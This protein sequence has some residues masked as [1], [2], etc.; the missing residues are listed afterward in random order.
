MSL[1]AQRFFVRYAWGVLGYTVLVVLWGAYVRASGSGAGCGSH[2]PLCNGEV[3]PRSA[4]AETLIEFT[5]RVTSGL[6]LLAVAGLWA[7]SRRLFARGHLARRAAAFSAVFLLIEAVLGAGLVLF[8]YVAQNASVGRALYLSAHL[9]N[10]QLLLAMLTLTAWFA[11]RPLKE[12]EWRALPGKFRAALP[13]ALL[14]GVTGAI[15]ALGDTLF[16]APS[17]AAGIRQETTGSPHWLLQLRLLHPAAS[18]LVGGF[19]LALALGAW[20]RGSDSALRQAGLW[21]GV[22]VLVQLAAGG[23]NVLLLAPIWMQIVHLLLADLL[24]IALV[25]LVV[26]EARR[27]ALAVIEPRPR[28]A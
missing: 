6:D 13:A 14:V 4:E 26:E 27:Q 12:L 10:T 3:I 17:M 20:R 21:T 5:H 16:P 19:L 2:W 24:W 23:I 9:A 18:I 8:E 25:I 7:W 15:A 22:L 11:G 1:P 28:R